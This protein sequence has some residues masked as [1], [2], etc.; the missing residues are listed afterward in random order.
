V[1][2]VPGGGAWPTSSWAPSQVI[3]DRI[4]LPVAQGAPAGEYV[5]AVGFYDPWYGGRLQVTSS[6]EAE[7]PVT[8]A[9]LP[10]HVT[11]SEELK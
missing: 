1:D 8:Q 2:R 3:V 7:G 6:D 11:V 4:E 10:V 9:V 5:I